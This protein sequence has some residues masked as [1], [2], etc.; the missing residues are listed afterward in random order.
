MG[1]YKDEEEFI[2]EAINSLLAI[3]KDLRIDIAC[4][5]Y[6]RGEISLGKACEIV[7]IDIEEMK[8]ILKKRNI[9][10]NENV[11]SK[12]MSEMAEEFLKIMGK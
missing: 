6:K 3:R 7:N 1:I 8:E 2:E 5:L 11:S 12:E 9:R 4:E 10:R